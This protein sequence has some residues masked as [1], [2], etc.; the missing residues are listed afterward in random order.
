MEKHPVIRERETSF[1]DI[2]QKQFRIFVVNCTMLM[3]EREQLF[4]TDADL[5]G[6]A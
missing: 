6:L 2:R 1:T 5:K 3:E 4:V